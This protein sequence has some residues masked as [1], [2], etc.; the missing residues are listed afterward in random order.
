V[1]APYDH[2][3][4]WSKAQ[5][6]L[7][8]AMDPEPGRSFDEQALWASAALELLGKAALARVSP[9][10]PQ[11]HPAGRHQPQA[12]TRA[13]QP[14]RQHRHGLDQMLAV[15]QQQQDPAVT[16]LLGDEPYRVPDPGVTPSSIATSASTTSADRIGARSASHTPAGNH[17]SSR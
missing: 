12:R 8:R 15:I 17:D 3:A 9:L 5:V 6:F 14:V 11:R 4:L 7:N 2:E 1:I 10:L 13:D 16:Q